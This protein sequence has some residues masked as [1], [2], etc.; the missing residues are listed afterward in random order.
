MN[1]LAH[2]RMVQDAVKGRF[3]GHTVLLNKS[4]P[5]YPEQAEREFKRVTNAYVNEI[6]ELIVEDSKDDKE[7]AYSKEVLDRRIR[8]IVGEEN[9]LPYDE[10]YGG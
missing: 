9:F 8:E 4:T 2:Q 1:N 7:L 3:K 5:Y 6:A 10:R